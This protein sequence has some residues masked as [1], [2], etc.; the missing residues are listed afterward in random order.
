MAHT[1]KIQLIYIM[2][3]PPEH[4]AEGDRIFASHQVWIEGSHHRDGEKALLSY[5]VSKAP[6]LSNP[7]DP[8]SPPTGNTCFILSEVYETEAGVA[9]HFE[10]AMGSW[11][12]FPALAAWL[13]NCTLSGVPI[14][15]IF[16]SLW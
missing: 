1:G 4:V 6:E 9:D 15:R 10:K 12:E 11:D 7:F 3:A 2:T 16:N 5:D 8:E 13:E 14:A